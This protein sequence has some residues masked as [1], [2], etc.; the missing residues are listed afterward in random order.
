M[1]SGKQNSL[2]LR[3][4]RVLV[5]SIFQFRLAVSTGFFMYAIDHQGNT[6]QLAITGLLQFVRVLLF[7]LF[8]F[9]LA[10]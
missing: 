7:V 5:S 3:S 6:A 4:C 9:R 10:F 8:P 1:T 2:Q